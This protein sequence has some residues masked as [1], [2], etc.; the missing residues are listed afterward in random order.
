MKRNVLTLQV[1]Q[2]RFIQNCNAMKLVVVG[3][4][5][6]TDERVTCVLKK[7]P[8]RHGDRNIKPVTHRRTYKAVITN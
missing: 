8:L 5:F 7:L 6:L 3:S 1:K 2:F 4:G